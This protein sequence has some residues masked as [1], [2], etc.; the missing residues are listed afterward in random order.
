MN[1][2]DGIG[3]G[4]VAA[5]TIASGVCFRVAQCH[6]AQV[7]PTMPLADAGDSQ[8]ADEMQ[9]HRRL[10]FVW[11]RRALA[12]A[13]LAFGTFWLAF[14]LNIAP[15]L[16]TI[17]HDHSLS[18][19]QP[20]KPSSSEKIDSGL[21]TYRIPNAYLPGRRSTGDI[22][23][24]TE[25]AMGPEYANF[26][27]GMLLPDFQPAAYNLAEFNETGWHHQ[28]R[29]LFEHK[30]HFLDNAEI[31]RNTLANGHLSE[32]DFTPDHGCRLYVGSMVTTAE[33]HVCYLPDRLFIF[34]C[35]NKDTR[36]LDPGVPSPN[37][38]VSE[39][40][41][42]DDHIIYDYSRD[43]VDQAVAIDNRIRELIRSFQ[44]EPATAGKAGR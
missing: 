30:M 15:E 28:L 2:L 37:C 40:I 42:P 43:F 39:N 9:Q 27:L 22:S 38:H 25:I 13:V 7:V 26:W 34:D 10:A 1:A 18:K 21:V 36:F 8:I 19:G 3:F 31:V 33:L 29:L 17:D 14:A 23:G 6:A 32:N 5:L 4:I 44:A 41:G 24:T 12:L 20:P 11:T 35:K 16:G